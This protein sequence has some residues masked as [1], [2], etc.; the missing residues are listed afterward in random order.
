MAEN[1][2]EPVPLPAYDFNPDDIVIL[3]VGPEKQNII[4][5]S[6]RMTAHSEFFAAALKK[7]WDEG[8]I[9]GV[10]LP[11]E[12]PEIMVYYI[13][14]VYSNKLPTDVYATTS[15]GEDKAQGY[16]LLAQIYVVAERL[17]DS[18]CRNR[19]LQE[20][21][22]FRNLLCTTG[23]R[24]NPTCVPI[25]IIYEGTTPGSPDRRLLVD[26]HAGYARGDWYPRDITL[27][28]SFLMDLVCRL[29][30]NV[31]T[32]KTVEYFRQIGLKKEYRV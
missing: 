3:L 6:P 24:W 30:R 19:I 2:K 15:P 29:L 5:H 25:N 28:P 8:Y 12:E 21:L 7:E 32:F 31:E 26:I 23:H 14:H 20:F 22:R 11:E 18:D 10:K 4:V 17:L 9:R 27:D 16:K 13:E 1:T